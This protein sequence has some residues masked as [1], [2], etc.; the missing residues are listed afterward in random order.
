MRI[1][2][3]P[4]RLRALRKQKAWS[5]DRTAA[6]TGVS[7]AMLGQI[8]RGESSPTVAT[9]WK[10]AS[11]LEVSFSSLFAANGDSASMSM[12]QTVSSDPDMQVTTVFPFA[13]DSRIEVFLIK[14]K[15]RKRLVRQ[16]HQAGIIEHVL[17]IRGEMELLCDGVWHRLKVGESK[18]FP[19]DQSHGYGAKA[20]GTRF[21]NIICYT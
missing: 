1:E 3:I 17:V 6:E 8:E 11:G 9:L 7:K 5:L 18:R 2:N 21:L 15:S 19:A 10:I 4:G 12:A 14:L 16:P 20:P 13:E